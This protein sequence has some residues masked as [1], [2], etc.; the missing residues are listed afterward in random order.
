MKTLATIVLALTLTG[1]GTV[2][3]QQPVAPPPTDQPSP[4]TPS[5]SP[6]TPPAPASAAPAPAGAPTGGQVL[7]DA[8]SLI[9]SVVRTPDGKD[10][11]KV[12]ALMIDPRDGRVASTVITVGGVL[13]VGGSTV[14]V[15]WSALHIGRDRHRF[16]VT[17][18][19]K[20]LEQA[21]AAS[22]ATDKK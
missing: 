8:G 16:V 9:G 3:A 14:S 19:Q 11:G 2:R 13:G 5:A 15:P 21:P 18:D 12:S 17:M 1:V 10:I 7:I 4:S 6:S 22:P 20:T